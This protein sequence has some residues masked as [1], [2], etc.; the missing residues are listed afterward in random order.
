M[1]DRESKLAVRQL[2]ELDLSDNNVFILAERELAAFAAAVKEL[3]GPEQARVSIAE[4]I[5]ELESVNLP[6]APEVSDFRRIT[7][8]ASN[9]L[10]FRNPVEAAWTADGEAASSRSDRL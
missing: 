4:W 8:A 2:E 7:T 9:R 10:A 6:G 3:F 1:R 5:D